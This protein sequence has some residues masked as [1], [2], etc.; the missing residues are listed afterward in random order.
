ML[1][2][3]VAVLLAVIIVVRLRRRT[4][5]RSRNDEKLTVLIVLVFGILVAPTAFG[6]GVL[7]VVSQLASGINDAGR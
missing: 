6:Q 5:A 1:T 7:D 3:N 4:H 2:I